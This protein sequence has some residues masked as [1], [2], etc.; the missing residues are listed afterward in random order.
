MKPGPR[1]YPERAWVAW[2]VEF[3]DSNTPQY[4]T[5]RGDGLIAWSPDIED[6]IQFKRKE[7][8]EKA[9]RLC[10]DLECVV[11]VQ[12]QWGFTDE[13]HRPPN[14]CDRIFEHKYLNPQ[15]VDEGC[16]ALCAAQEI[17]R[18]RRALKEAVALGSIEFQ[19]PEENGA[20]FCWTQS[21][22]GLGYPELVR[23]L[24]ENR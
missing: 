6:A 20:L 8:A 4:L 22:T 10:G 2:V 14:P 13:L 15:C 11:P 3:W 12:H 18:L 9:I 7:D 21:A 1:P 23:W 17:E 19:G 5:F 16:Q 24:K